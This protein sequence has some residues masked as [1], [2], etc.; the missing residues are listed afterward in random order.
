MNYYLLKVSYHFVIFISF[1]FCQLIISNFKQGLDDKK[2]YIDDQLIKTC[3][4]PHAN[5]SRDQLSE[6]IKAKSLSL[7]KK[8]WSFSANVNA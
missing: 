4:T 3:E 2:E 8:K 1:F 5:N 6:I 7:H